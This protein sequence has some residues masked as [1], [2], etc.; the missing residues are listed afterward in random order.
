M[1]LILLTSMNEEWNVPDQRQLASQSDSQHAT[2]NQIELNVS[3]S[4]DRACDQSS[5]DGV[6]FS[7]F[8]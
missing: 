6:L 5:D 1:E 4:S 8:S 7:H 2:W 3:C